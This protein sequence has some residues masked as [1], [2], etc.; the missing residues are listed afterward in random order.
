[1]PAAPSP[2]WPALVRAGAHLT[3]RLPPHTG[4]RHCTRQRGAL[5]LAEGVIP[6]D[7]DVVHP[8][9]RREGAV[10]VEAV[11][12]EEAW[13]DDSDEDG[14]ED[15]HLNIPTRRANANAIVESDQESDSD[16]GVPAT[17]LTEKAT[18]RVGAMMAHR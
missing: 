14:E 2:C 9:Q 13:G 7:E 15:E 12:D 4:K 18:M 17:D 5:A 16:T 11:E 3:A 1:M 8:P 10:A 6:Q